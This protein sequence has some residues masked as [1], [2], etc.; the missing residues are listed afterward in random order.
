MP[1]GLYLGEWLGMDLVNAGQIQSAVNGAVRLAFGTSV[2]E[3]TWASLPLLLEMGL[4]LVHQAMSQNRAR[5]Y[6]KSSSLQSRLKEMCTPPHKVAL[7]G[8]AAFG[9]G[10][11][12]VEVLC[13]RRK[14]VPYHCSPPLFTPVTQMM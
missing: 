7:H 13:M 9:G 2:R 3:S 11:C 1:Q 8:H 10:I 5:L 6:L 14:A 12:L 4:P